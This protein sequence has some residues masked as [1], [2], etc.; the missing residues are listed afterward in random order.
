MDNEPIG[1]LREICKGLPEAT[2]GVTVHHPSLKI[3]DKTIVMF[4]DGDDR[5]ALWIK[6][7]PGIQ[8][9]LVATD[10]ERFF[11]PPY[12]G[13]KGWVGVRLDRAVDWTEVAELV[14]DGY[15]LLAPKR[16]VRLLDEA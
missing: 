14:T 3:R 15:R 4:A 2:E 16:L 8:Q 9:E 10:P 12:V 5:P 11:I 7:A 6:A 13:P 1:R